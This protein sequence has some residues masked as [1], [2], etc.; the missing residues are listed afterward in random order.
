M[1]TEG[2]FRV[3]CGL[4]RQS[5]DNGVMADQNRPMKM[6]TDLHAQFVIDILKA[7]QSVDAAADLLRLGWDQIHGS[8]D[9]GAVSSLL[10]LPLRQTSH[11][12]CCQQRP[13]L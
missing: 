8:N 2:F 12:E 1:T 7:S 4:A 11:H 5:A 3:H 6:N 9:Q 13:Q 10:V